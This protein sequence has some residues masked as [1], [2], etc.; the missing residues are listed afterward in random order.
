MKYLLIS[1]GLW[2]AVTSDEANAEADQK[3]LA[4]IGLYVKEHHL[5]MLERCGTARDAWN[6]LEE[7][8]QAKSNARKLQLRKELIQLKMGASE[9]LTKYVARAK[10]LQDQLRAAGHEVADQDV[11]WSVLAGLPADYDTVVTILETTT[12]HDMSLDDILPK[13]LQVEQRQQKERPTDTALIAQPNGGYGGGK[14]GKYGHGKFPGSKPGSKGAGNGSGSKREDRTCYYCGKR[15]HISTDCR[16]K[17][18]DIAAGRHQQQR[19]QQPQ[20]YGAIALAAAE[21][22]V[23]ADSNAGSSIHRWVLDTGASRHITP[24]GDIMFNKRPLSEDI[25][26]TFGNGSTGKATAVGDVLFTSASAAA[27]LVLTNVLHIPEA[28][29]NLISVRY[30]TQ[31][32]LE[33]SF[34]TAGCTIQRDGMTLA[35]A[36]SR[37]DYIYYISG[38]CPTPGQKAF[39]A[40]AMTPAL[41]GRT[42][43]ESPQLWHKRFGHLGYDNLAKLQSQH[44]VTGIKTS[45]DQFK[46]AGTA[47]VCEPCVLGKQHRLPFKASTSDTSRPLQ[48]VHTDLCGPMPVASIGGNLYFATV[49]DDYSKLS[50]VLPLAR[51]SDTAAAVREAIALLENQ[52]GYSVQRLRC[53]NGSEYINQSLADYLKAKGIKLETSVR[54]TPEQNGAAER[55]NRTL[56]DKV[57]S[58]LADSGLPKSLWAEALATANYLRNRSPVNGRNLTPLELFSGTKPDVSHLRTF[59]ARAYALTPKQLRTKL[60]NTSQPGRLIGYPAGSKGYKLLLDNGS[61]ITSRDVIFDEGEAGAV[62][63]QP[64]SASTSEAD[65]V[66]IDISNQGDSEP[67]GEPEEPPPG[68]EQAAGDAD[69]PARPTRA[70]AG[71]PASVWLEN[72]YRI[73]GRHNDN[74]ATQSAHLATID[75]PT[76]MAAA[77]ASEQADLWRQAMDEEYASLL[78]NGT[79]TLEEVPPGVKPIPTKWVYKLKR[80][81]SGNIERYKARLVVQGFRQREG[82]DYEEVFAPV[83]K[84]STLRAVLAVAASADLDLHHL[85]IK[86]AFLNGELEEEVWTMQPPGYEEGSG[87][88]ACRLHKALYGLKQAPRAWHQRLQSELEAIGFS[89]CPADPALFIK[90][91]STT[92]YLLTY[93]DDLLLASGD[94][95]ELQSVKQ[96][97]MGAFDARDLGE[98]TYFLGMDIIRDRGNRT[99]KLAQGRLTVDLLTKFDMA[100][101]RTLSTPLN[102]STRLVKEGEPLDRQANGYAQLVGSLMYLSVCTRP[103]IA[104]AVGALARYMAAPTVAHWQAAKGVLRYLAGT[105]D[106]G[107]IYGRTLGLDVYCDADYA[108]DIDTRRSTTAYV[109]IMN[110]GAISWSSRL[111]QTVAASTTEAEYMA[112]AATVKE[113]LWLRTLL[114]CLGQSSETIAIKADSQSAIKLLKN[115]VFS[116]RSKHIDVIYHFA[117]ERVA[118]KDVSFTYIKTDD[119]VADMLTKPLPA[120][121][122][123]AHRTAMGVVSCS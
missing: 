39:V 48:L 91:G 108:G 43:A 15:G 47:A 73:T 9:P 118:R 52:S 28:M 30:A 100:E 89:A 40:A 103:D 29:E 78:S 82:I 123:Q 5:P 46:T 88:L 59:G 101:V 117:R 87:S 42:T 23:T 76:S 22:S 36:P 25:T 110:G 18:S 16:K 75:E 99:I 11:A 94:S 6:Q 71:R 24:H 8:Y 84:Y 79:W 113:A 115:P 69:R 104:Q 68:D 81:S 4:L 32:G 121:K 97:L 93:V 13:L 62:P 27:P 98:A 53:D 1:R 20:Q 26:I 44:M 65:T 120:A 96:R 3:A 106:Y 2:T 51:K 38:K 74:P 14:P 83:S 122:F 50:I 34:T 31:R 49:L 57:R 112:A 21:A 119:M 85:D 60:E 33:F 70:A 19:Q 92:V 66:T 64:L 109:F 95:G 56:L 111:Q 90:D 55:L 107:I 105:A 17:K 77:L 116:M 41:L 35:T 86:T 114:S 7:V 10:E 63:D 61:I 45:A 12:E 37:S 102:T 80:G 54:Y 67:V 58:M 72:S